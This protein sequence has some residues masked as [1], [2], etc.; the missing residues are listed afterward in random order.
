[1]QKHLQNLIKI[2]TGVGLD[3]YDQAGTHG[4]IVHAHLEKEILPLQKGWIPWRSS[5][6][7]SEY[8]P[9]LASD[10]LGVIHPDIVF[11]GGFTG[12]R[13]ITQLAE[14]FYIPVVATISVL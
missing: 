3:G 7:T 5:C 2:E 1:M 4:P 8:Y 13:R 11:A 14:L 10:T 12:C 9:F 6:T